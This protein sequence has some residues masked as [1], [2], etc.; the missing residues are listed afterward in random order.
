MAMDTIFLNTQGHDGSTCG[1]VFFGLVSRMLNF[2]PM[3]SKASSNVV[4]AYQDFMRDEGVPECLHRDLAPEEKT[5]KI[6]DI[7]RDMMVRDSWAEAGNGCEAFE[8]RSA[9]TAEWNWHA[10]QILAFCL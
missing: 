4:K 10:K 3:P 5:S 2:H 6:T 8:N 9:S 1:Q 7:N